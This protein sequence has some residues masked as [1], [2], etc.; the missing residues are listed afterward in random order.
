[1]NPG[2]TVLRPGY[3]AHF[4]GNRGTPLSYESDYCPGEIHF[5]V[6]VMDAPDIY[7]PQRHVFH[8]EH[9][10]WL[11]LNDALPRYEGL[12]KDEPA[13]WDSRHRKE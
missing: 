10:S 4:R 9:I 13:S 6:S 8:E 1:M 3:T 11:E 12:D 7:L 5:Y 2:P